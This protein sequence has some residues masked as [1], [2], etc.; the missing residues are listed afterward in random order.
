MPCSGLRS[1]RPDSRRVSAVLNGRIRVSAVASNGQPH[2]RRLYPQ[3]SKGIFDSDAT[4]LRGG[5][6][7]TEQETESNEP[8]NRS[9]KKTRKVKNSDDQSKHNKRGTEICDKWNQGRCGV[10]KPQSKCTAGRSHQCSACLRTWQRTAKQRSD[11]RS[12]RRRKLLRP[13]VL[14][15]S[16]WV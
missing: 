13:R 5:R 11:L 3:A 8:A 4:W 9:G 12:P 16:L 15:T 6:K 7:L 2:S 1:Y 10:P 14:P